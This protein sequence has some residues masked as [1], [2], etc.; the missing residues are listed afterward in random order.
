MASGS[1]FGV[2]ATRSAERAIRGLRGTTARRYAQFET[3]LRAQGCRAAGYRLLA[4]NHGEFS[5]YCCKHLDR[6]WRVLTTFDPG[7]VTIVAVGEHDGEAFYQ[8]VA[9]T[10]GIRPVGSKREAK[11]PCC[12]NDGW[13]SVGTAR[14][15]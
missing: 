5:S 4:P 14:H 15:L 6:R 12:G 7:L 1:G 10:L 3:E 9:S 8:Q 13:P 11:P 2:R